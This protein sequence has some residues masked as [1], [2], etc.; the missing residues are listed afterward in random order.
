[1]RVHH[2]LPP[3]RGKSV[4]LSPTSLNPLCLGISAALVPLP[5]KHAYGVMHCASVLVLQRWP[6][7]PSSCRCPSCLRLLGCSKRHK[8]HAITCN[9]A[10]IPHSTV[11]TAVCKCSGSSA[12]PI[13]S[14]NIRNLGLGRALVNKSA[15]LYFPG[16]KM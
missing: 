2:C 15:G 11:H 5:T 7:A 6:D 12:I 1:M 4:W 16:I 10:N 14:L 9:P 3:V 8:Q 13:I